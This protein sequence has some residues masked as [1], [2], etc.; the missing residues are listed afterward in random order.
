MLVSPYKN[1]TQYSK[2][3]V[4]PNQMNS[5]IKNIVKMTL[6]K[7]VEKKC[8]KNGF[9]DEVY[10][11]EESEAMDMEPE[12]LSGCCNFKVSFHCRICIPVENTQLVVQIKN[13]NQVLI[14]A[15]N[16]PIMIF[17]PKENIDLDVWDIYDH[18]LHKKTKEVL[19]VNSFVKVEVIKARINQLDYQI[20][21][22]GKLLDFATEDEVNKYYGNVVEDDAMPKIGDDSKEPESVDQMINQEE[23]D[24][25][26]NDGD[27]DS[28]EGG[29]D[30]FESDIFI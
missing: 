8:N 11:I 18:F 26:I 3:Q 21:V 20:K 30:D 2:I 15:V 19:K 16:G 28:Q 24:D 25:D 9:I 10:R 5:D 12:N 1:I 7:K 17:I 13:L 29:Y 14:L 22:I 27:S 23:E 6:R 4:K